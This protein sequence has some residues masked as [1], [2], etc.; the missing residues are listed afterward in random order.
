[1]VVMYMAQVVTQWCYVTVNSCC[2]NMHNSF[3][4]YDINCNITQLHLHLLQLLLIV[5][6]KR[7][8]H[9]ITLVK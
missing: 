2:Y 1:M 9:V 7:L 4:M 3:Y 8:S 6:D 5:F